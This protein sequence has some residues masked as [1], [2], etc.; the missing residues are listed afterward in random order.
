[1][2]TYEEFKK[3]DM[4]G[5]GLLTIINEVSTG[6]LRELIK[7]LGITSDTLEFY[8]TIDFQKKRDNLQNAPSDM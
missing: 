7:D 6:D 3:K 2:P 4:L 8:N 5:H 1:M